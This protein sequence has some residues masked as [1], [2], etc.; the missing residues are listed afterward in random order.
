[1]W[2]RIITIE[3]LAGVIAI[4]PL[5]G[6]PCPMSPPMVL[7][8]SPADNATSVPLTATVSVTFDRAAIPESLQGSITPEIEFTQAWSQD[9]TVVTVTPSTPL[10]SNTTYTVTVSACSFADACSLM[11]PVTFGFTTA[12]TIPPPESGFYVSA[13]ASGASD[14]NDGL[15]PTY[16]GGM[17]GPWLTIG[18]AVATMRAGDTTHVLPG[19]YQESM[20]RFSH[21]GTA[22]A[23]ILLSGAGSADVIVDG[24]G[25]QAGMIIDPGV[26]YVTLQG[27][28]VR[29]L[30]EHG[31][32]VGLEVS[33]QR[34]AGIEMR[35]VYVSNY[36]GGTSLYAAGVIMYN[37]DEF[38]LDDL[39]TSDGA[40]NGVQ[41]VSCTNGTVTDSRLH[42]NTA[43]LSNG[44]EIQQGHDITVSNCVAYDND[45][46]GF[47]ISL[48]PKEPPFAHSITIEGCFAY[49]NR[50]AGFAA[51]SRAHDLIFRRNVAWRNCHASPSNEM[52]GFVC[53]DGAYDVT[54]EH[55]VSIDNNGPGFFVSNSSW[56][57]VIAFAPLPSNSHTF[58]NNIAH[59]NGSEW[60]ALY[61]PG[62][63]EW[64]VIA[65]HITPA[66]KRWT[67]LPCGIAYGL[68]LEVTLDDVGSALGVAEI[69]FEIGDQ[70]RFAGG[71][72]A[73][74][75]VGLDVVV[76]VLVGV[77]FGAVAR[78]EEQ[79]DPTPVGV[80]PVAR[81]R[82]AM[83]RMPI[84]DQEHAPPPL[85]QQPPAEADEHFGVERALE[86]QEA[87]MAAV[88]DARH[89]I[90]PEPLPRTRNHRRPAAAAVAAAGL[91]IAARPELVAPVNLGVFG[92]GLLRDRRVRVL[93]PVR[94]R[95]RVA[96][97]G[98]PQRLLRCEAPAFQIAAHR[99][100]RNLQARPLRDQVADRFARPE[101]E[102]QL[103]LIGR[104]IG[105]L[106]HDGCGLVRGQTRFWSPPAL[107]RTQRGDVALR[108][109][110]Q[111][112]VDR[113]SR[114]AEGACRRRLRHAAANGRDDPH[115]NLLLGIRREPTCIEVTHTESISQQFDMSNIM[116]PD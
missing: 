92:L 74:D 64:T 82:R 63:N 98:P 2:P 78:Q 70:F 28:T 72:L 53:Y 26:G 29:N 61:V 36:G 10:A 5:N 13:N 81:R 35:D 58:R 112:G 21:A 48:W 49:D 105:D 80:Q 87:Q 60:P 103:E 6:C 66:T 51:N 114:D 76:Q 40:F 33:A 94:H 23:P 95:R 7:T 77:Q 19:T 43:P 56:D 88:G 79:A 8:T 30:A 27:L 24:G 62:T 110:P 68:G 34:T 83:H 73:A 104:A 9:N 54:F 102:G 115:P 86:D 55:N 116:C 47:D 4:M 22:S 100:H 111:P 107:L 17:R 32:V 96:L 75:G 90:G 91:M 85:T 39:E 14:N 97:V 45:G 71:A 67:R 1:M 31:I 101:R 113:G 11:A 25:S 18:H 42:G 106:L 38:S 65:E 46:Y 59:G 93:L 57:Q 84:H 52:G 69:V 108:N 41:L 20:I 89:Q 109:L 3:L 15:A 99:P 12:G 50:N 16:E 44:I 37:V